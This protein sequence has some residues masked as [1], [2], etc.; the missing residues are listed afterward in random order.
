MR[1]IRTGD[2]YRR[3]WVLDDGTVYEACQTPSKRW[4]VTVTTP[5]GRPENLPLYHN[6]FQVE[7]MVISKEP[8]QTELF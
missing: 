5:G 1:T 3:Q 4:A 2:R 6:I 7:L 8:Q